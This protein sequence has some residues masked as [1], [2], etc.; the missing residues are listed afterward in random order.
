[1]AATTADGQ[2]QR[3]DVL[4][5]GDVRAQAQEDASDAKRAEAAQEGPPQLSLFAGGT[6]ALKSRLQVTGGATEIPIQMPRGSKVECIVRGRIKTVKFDDV[7]GF[8]DSA[9]ATKREHVLVV[10]SVELTEINGQSIDQGTLASD[11]PDDAD[12]YDPAEE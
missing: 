8:G 7:G 10:E 12:F 9:Q 1:M 3:E 5:D 4:Q 6:A 11:P 2:T